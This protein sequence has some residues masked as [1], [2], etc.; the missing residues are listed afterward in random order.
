MSARTQAGTINDWLWGALR[1]NPEGLLLLAAGAVLLMRKSAG[2]T[3]S[4]LDVERV[5]RGNIEMNS[6]EKLSR[7]GGGE[8]TR[9]QTHK[10]HHT[11]AATSETEARKF[12]ASLSYRVAMRRKSLSR[13]KAF[14]IR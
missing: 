3:A 12:L 6:G 4:G 1:Q 2:P 7:D 8:G 14:S 9:A 11:I 5:A 10:I 13:Q